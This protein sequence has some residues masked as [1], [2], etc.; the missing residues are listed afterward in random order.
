[1]NADLDTDLLRTFVA[2][3]D[4]GG[5]TRAAQLVHRTQ[6]AV[7]MQMKRLEESVGK[8]LFERDGRSVVL[9]VEGETLLGY[10]RRILKLHAE[11]LATLTQPDMVGAVRIGTPDDYVA[12]FLPGILTRFAHAYPQVQVEVRCEPSFV[13]NEALERG[14]LDLALVT[15]VNNPIE[16]DIV[17]RD[18]VVWATSDKHFAHE[19]NPLPLALFQSG[20]FF[21]HWA[22][23]A[24]DNLE[25]EYR[26]AYTSP[27]INGIQAV[28]SAGLAVTVLAQS[29]LPPGVRALT[30]AE[31]FPPFP[32]AAIVL[33]RAPTVRSR[34][35][36]CMARHITEGFA[37][38]EAQVA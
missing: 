38:N 25:R 22:I 37:V 30:A 3:A 16:G 2:I 32:Q 31:G 20:C 4:A 29:I 5:F 27:S 36:D 21:R 15:D 33:K 6:S 26:I 14:E 10:A 7:S 34:V 1:M 9:T 12:R 35:I 13:L 23:K 19:Q 17:R 28:V 18:P 11:V 8:P 24:L